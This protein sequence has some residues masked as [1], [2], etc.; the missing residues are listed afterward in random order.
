MSLKKSISELNREKQKKAILDLLPK[1]R[2]SVSK[3]CEK[4][5]IHRNTLLNWKNNDEN[6]R[7]EYIAVLE[8]KIDDSEERLYLLSQGIPEI[9][10]NGKLIGWKVK[11]HFGALVAQLKAQAKN[12]GYGDQITINDM[13]VIE[14]N[15]SVKTE[16]ELIQEM[17]KIQNSNSNSN[18][19]F[20]I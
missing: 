20:N 16:Q 10:E 15:I 17:I 1:L 9:D 3:T 4:V 7:K 2:Y 14:Q 12:R 13:Q 8:K 5:G 19:D 6:F 11:P 18:N